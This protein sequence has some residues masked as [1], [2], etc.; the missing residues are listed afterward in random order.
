MNITKLIK[1]IKMNTEQ[2]I[3]G[4]KIVFTNWKTALTKFLE[5]EMSKNPDLC[6]P[7]AKYLSQFIE[8]MDLIKN[9]IAN[10]S[11]SISLQMMIRA[12]ASYEP[13][14][15]LPSLKDLTKLFPS[16]KNEFQSIFNIEENKFIWVSS[17]I[18]KTL[19]IKNEEFNLENL[20]GI[21]GEPLIVNEDLPHFMRWAGISYLLFSIPGFKFE[22]NNDYQLI[23]F[24][25]NTSK[26]TIQE[27]VNLNSLV[28][29][30]KS[31]LHISD[32]S[33]AEGGIPKYHFDT[34]TIYDSSFF[35]NVKPHYVTSFSQSSFMND[36]AYLI[37]C[38]LI[39]FPVKYLLILNERSKL[40]R[41]KLV[42][43]TMNEKLEKLAKLEGNLDEYKIGDYLNKSIKPKLTTVCKNWCPELKEDIIGDYEAINYAKKMGIIPIPS[44]VESLLYSLSDKSA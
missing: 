39:D 4:Q 13:D 16:S 24:R 3:K 36:L 5:S 41:N 1:P 23:K 34:W 35:E 12:M 43:H 33:M 9:D 32:D 6:L 11:A 29:A 26:S 19:G 38:I 15:D 44:Q 18:E 40:D 25:I 22:S 28:L 27:I 14:K 17:N 8:K 10:K 37:N 30:K 20:I 21:N 7:V 2:E 42:A 31:Q